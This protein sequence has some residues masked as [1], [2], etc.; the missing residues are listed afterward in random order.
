VLRF[1]CPGHDAG[2]ATN[3]ATLTF[4]HPTFTP[5]VA[6]E[7][8]CCCPLAADYT[9]PWATLLARTRPLFK[10]RWSAFVRPA[11]TSRPHRIYLMEPYAPDRIPVIMVHGLRSTP[12]V[13][14]ELTNELMG[15]P[16]IRRRFQIW[17]YL[18]PTGLPF[19]TSA[20]DF[21]DD[22]EDLRRMLDPQGR[23]F[24]TQHMIVIGHSM[25]GLLARTLVT[26][27]GDAMWNSTFSKPAAEVEPGLKTI[28]ELRRM[29]YFQPKPYVKRAIFM[30]VPHHGSKTADGLL[31]RLVSQRVRLP[32]NLHAFIA[33][34]RAVLPDL[35]KPEAAALFN[36]GYP[37]S[38]RVLAPRT[39]GLV[40]LAKLPVAPSIP[41]HSI[42]GDKGSGHGTNSSDGFVTYSSAHL[43]GA[44]SEKFVPADHSV[45][46]NPEAIAEVKRI[47]RQHVSELGRESKER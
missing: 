36:R 31:G 21:R 43:A 8:R 12:L 3:T 47:L 18:Y 20:A 2:R 15:D 14:E 7:D 27:S 1:Q 23:D 13:W 38:I 25:G 29:F 30:A 26:D 9:M 4:Y 35:L 16:G 17:H 10:T 34:L 33:D 40:A 5:E 22:L 42:M 45:Y 19:L 37:T 11:E 32:G 46:A 24:A 44:A 6:I 41:F 39:E 28:A